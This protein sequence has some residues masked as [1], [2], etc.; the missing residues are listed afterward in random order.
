M[1]GQKV[2]FP[3]V[4]WE[5]GEK[6][7]SY[8]QGVIKGPAYIIQE[9]FGY[10]G[11]APTEHCIAANEIKPLG[12]RRRRISRKNNRKSKRSISRRV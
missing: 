5:R 11:Y 8:R 3:V 9:P 6:I 10:P 2:H 12:G 4:D 1:S 7:T